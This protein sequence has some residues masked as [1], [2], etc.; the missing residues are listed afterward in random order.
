[1]AMENLEA[2]DSINAIN[3]AP[4]VDVCLVLLLVFMVT[5]PLSALYGVTVKTDK[6]SKYGVTKPQDNVMVHLAANGIFIEND[7]R[8][9]ELV[10]YEEFGV[11]IRQLIQLSATRA[12]ILKI[13]A[14]VPHGQTV[15]ALDV[16]KQNGASQISLFEGGAS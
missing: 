15:W 10:P 6:L 1:M 5:M 14:A 4:L 2:D 11:V 9:E 13:D 16:A 7:R 8:K 3:I 12:V